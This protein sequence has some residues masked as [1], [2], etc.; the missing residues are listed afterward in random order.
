M[1]RFAA[2]VCCA[3]ALTMV[4]G[5]TLSARAELRAVKLFG[6]D[7]VRVRDWAAANKFQVRWLEP[8]RRAL[9]TNATHRLVLTANSPQAEL[10]GIKIW[11]AF[12]VVASGGGLCLS[13]VD[14][15]TTVTPLLFPP[16]N[17]SGRKVKTIVLD[18]GH[19]GKDPGNRVGAE[20]EK[21]YT[22]LLAQEI[23]DLLKPS[24]VKV[25]F[26]RTSDKFVELADRPAKAQQ[27]GGDLFVSLHFNATAEGRNEVQGSEVYC[28]TPV[29]ATS[30]NTRGEGNTSRVAGNRHNDQS[31]LLAYQIQKA[32]QAGTVSEDRGVRRAR[33]AVL[34]DAAMPAALVEAGFMS[35]PVEAKKIFNSTSRREMAR[36][37]VKGILAYKRDVGG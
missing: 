9:L 18:P 14:L 13:S 31:T 25:V 36:A 27:A 32:L 24:G 22:L 19:G 17:P 5:V 37:I 15:Q 2:A 20:A 30:T 10:N 11:L 23:K 6:R 4:G 12:P 29:G 8:D 3:L 7:H 34:R 21:K 16:R 28:L 35:H 33:F 1:K 26:T